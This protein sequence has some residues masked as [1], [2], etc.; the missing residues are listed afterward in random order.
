M[1]EP[2]DVKILVVDDEP[3]LRKA[4]VF[5]FKRR[6]Y[7]VQEAEN[8]KEAFEI[9]KASHFDIVLTDVRMPNGDGIELLDRIKEL[10]PNVPV[11]MFITGFADM[12]T[13]DAYHKGVDAIFP[14][15]FDRKSLFAAVERATLGRDTVWSARAGER[16]QVD[17][18]I[19]LKFGEFSQA[20]QGHVINI[21]RGGIYVALK[22]NIPPVN[23]KV[24]FQITFAKG[25]PREI[26]GNGVVRWIRTTDAPDAPAGCGLEFEYLTDESRKEILALLSGAN[27]K[28]FIPKV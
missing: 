14:K 19:E 1:R 4:V 11:V 21:G 17:C 13:E 25:L 8:G 7:Q 16:A 28:P 15:P 23:T 26:S 20:C 12:T 5:D 18:T 10:N 24:S 2:K 27:I 9:F 6:G 3:G 22:D